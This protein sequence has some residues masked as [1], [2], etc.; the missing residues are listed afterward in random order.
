MALI[1]NYIKKKDNSFDIRPNESG[2]GGLLIDRYST[3]KKRE[4]NIIEIEEKKPLFERIKTGVKNL[5][6]K[7]EEKKKEEPKKVNRTLN[8]L[9]GVGSGGVMPPQLGI[10]DQDLRATKSVASGLA[11]LAS[12]FVDVTTSITERLENQ[13]RKNVEAMTDPVE[14]EKAMKA[15]FPTDARASADTRKVSKKMK[16]WA[17]E[18]MPEDPNYFDKIMAGVG[19][20]SGFM[21]IN[22]VSGGSTVLPMFLESVG[23]MGSAYE[24]N[25]D[26]GVSIE[27]SGKRADMVF[28]LNLVLNTALNVFDIPKQ[29]IKKIA[30][31]IKGVG[32]EG[33]QEGLQQLIS[34]IYTKRP[35]I[36]GFFES[37]GIGAILGGGTT[38]ILPSGDGGPD[39]QYEKRKEEVKFEPVEIVRQEARVVGE[40]KVVETEEKAMAKDK[41]GSVMKSPFGDTLPLNKDGKITVYHRTT[42]EIAE[43]INV[44]GFKGTIIQGEEGRVYFST[45]PEGGKAIGKEKTAVIK[46]DIDP[47]KT[48]IDEVYRDGSFDLYADEKDM[49][50]IILEKKAKKP[51]AVGGVGET[52][53]VY[54][55]EL[56]KLDQKKV[57]ELYRKETGDTG[58]LQVV[59]G[60]L[61][62]VYFDPKTL[63]PFEDVKL[64]VVGK[65]QKE[66]DVSKISKE[67]EEAKK[68]H[69][70]LLSGKA[71]DSELTAIV[72]KKNDLAKQVF[73]VKI[74]VE[75]NVGWANFY[76]A[77]NGWF[78]RDV[79]NE[80]KTSIGAYITENSGSANILFDPTPENMSIVEK[81]LQKNGFFTDSKRPK[82]V[83]EVEITKATDVTGKEQ[84]ILKI[85][86]DKG[87]KLFSSL[88]FEQQ[89]NKNFWKKGDTYTHYNTVDKT[90]HIDGEIPELSQPKAV[91]GVGKKPQV[92]EKSLSQ[93]QAEANKL[94]EAFHKTEVAEK[95][96]YNLMREWRKAQNKVD[97]FQAKQIADK[98]SVRTSER[99]KVDAKLREADITIDNI[100][101]TDT[102]FLINEA[103]KHKTLDEFL[104]VMHG[105]ATQYGEYSPEL[106][107]FVGA[108]SKT[109]DQMTEF[110]PDE[111]VTVYRGVDEDLNG[112]EA[113][114]NDGDFVTMDSA[115]AEQYIGP[116]GQVV[117]KEVEA[118]Y[119]INEYPDEEVED[120][121]FYELIYQTEPFVKITDSK[122]TDIYNQATKPVPAKTVIP[123]PPKIKEVT[124]RQVENTKNLK[125]TK[126]T[127]KNIRQELSEAVVEAEG[128]SMVAQ[129][130]RA[131]LNTQDIAKLKSTVAVNKKFR[132]GDIE[133]VRASKAGELVNRVVENV[134][135]VHPEMSDEEAYD[136]ALNL[137]TK[138]QES[139]RNAVIRELEKKEKK[140]SKFLDLLKTKQDDLKIKVDDE[141]SKEWERAL[142][143]QEKLIQI[144][145]VPSSQLPVGTGPKRVSGLGARLKGALKSASQEEIDDLGLSTYNQSIQ[146]EQI[147][148]AMEYTQAN[149]DEAL[150]VNSGEIDPPPGILKNSIFG[151]LVE[152]GSQD[153]DLATKIA[154]QTST[155]YGQEIN[156]LKTILADNPVVMM[157]EVANVR[158]E[159]YEKR[160]GKKATERV[161]KEIDKINKEV[162]AP[163]R[164]EWDSFIEK[165]RC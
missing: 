53:G 60:A 74:S 150:R 14:R 58:R 93:L 142:A 11:G 161:K 37:M 140:L 149:P 1:D 126:S 98:E 82:A 78:N 121:Q 106:R 81:V 133:T 157:Q 83:G 77:G 13:Q 55:E 108:E 80:L 75:N 57:V 18:M 85:T 56:S 99:Q 90:W 84:D 125:D 9:A 118:K 124:T 163:D 155:R 100:S 144:V 76:E 103:K 128:L 136:F 148:L 47:Q 48:L 132:E 28:G 94:H 87:E 92:E 112:E 88:G 5:F 10:K 43:K 107:R 86:K 95:P 41:E 63:K 22:A 151:A 131:G 70:R 79:F 21:A 113:I 111:L 153:T 7:K 34:N 72:K 73:P 32:T 97:E 165:I 145:R 44:D 134:Q 158:I 39:K 67:L 26:A 105:S 3:K 139:P 129:E 102:G 91:G 27:E 101:E 30:A 59:E 8:F 154:T 38:L 104:Q 117:E 49:V 45:R 61:E 54:F 141:L 110:E 4:P 2:G 127:L 31:V 40:E 24:D 64:K 119:L 68:E 152:L 147:A 146:D 52:K 156:I 160:T 19:S 66:V 115:D 138:A 135:E 6:A 122:L 159:A 143:V 89:P 65:F 162:K 20:M 36:E 130:Q 25:R 50:D 16:L 51:K 33:L 116:D 137:P 35:L 164:S 46:F 69:T 71:S 12:S 62:G 96:D 120:N 109:L 114:I 42:P 23:E 123:K 15:S 17:A 29:N